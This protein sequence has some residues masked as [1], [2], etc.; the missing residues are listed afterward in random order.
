[1]LAIDNNSQ[2]TVTLSK[3]LRAPGEGQQ[4]TVYSYFD[5]AIYGGVLGF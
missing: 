1:M 5:T 2:V 3:C 4:S